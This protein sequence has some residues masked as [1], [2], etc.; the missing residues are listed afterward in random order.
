V[1]DIKSDRILVVKPEFSENCSFEVFIDGVKQVNKDKE[2]YSFNVKSPEHGG[3]KI[4]IIVNAGNIIIRS[5]HAIA[6]Y[7][8][9]VYGKWK[10][11]PIYQESYIKWMNGENI[12]PIELKSGN[13]IEY[14]HLFPNGPNYV[15]YHI[16]YDIK[17]V[18][19]D[20][21]ENTKSVLDNL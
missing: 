7:P 1:H 10:R 9:Y 5:H 15:E 17:P 14:Y 21:E 2:L 3:K 12:F 13:E 4:K 18:S 20:I 11:L 8:L 6:Y 16:E 19:N